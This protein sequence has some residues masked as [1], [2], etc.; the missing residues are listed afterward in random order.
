M[1]LIGVAGHSSTGKTTGFRNMPPKETVM[2][3]PNNKTQ[4][5]FKGAKKNYVKYNA[6]SHTG[7]LILTN[8]IRAISKA[9]KEVNDNRPEVK[10]FL[11]DDMTHFFNA[12]TQSEKFRGRN[13]GGEAFSRWA[14]FAAMTFATVFD[15]T[16]SFRDDLSVIIHFHV[17][18]LESFEGT[19]LKLKTPGK[20]LDRDIDIPSYFTYM[21]YT[22]VLPPSKDYTTEERYKYVTNDDG[23]RP[24][25]TPMGCF[26]DL[27]IP[28]DMYEVIKAIEAFE[29]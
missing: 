5:P 28:N 24:A 25:K 3:L 20:M 23:V 29:N 14:D 4:L 21:L 12:E 18:E 17:E 15:K 10:Y 1:R 6:D 19:K 13:S 2:M 27:E 9:L 11:I 26:K 22:K 16:D 7:N 8:K